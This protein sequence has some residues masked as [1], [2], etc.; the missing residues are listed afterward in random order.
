MTGSLPPVRDGVGDW[1]FNILKRIDREE[2]EIEKLYI[3]TSPSCAFHSFSEKAEYIPVEDYGV[4]SIL[5]VVR[6]LK[7]SKVDVLHLEYNCVGYGKRL[8]VNLLPFL[9]KIGL[10]E[11]G[12]I[13]T[14][15]EYDSYTW[16]GKTRMLPMIW[17]SEKIFFTDKINYHRIRKFK[18]NTSLET[19]YAPPNIAVHEGQTNED[20]ATGDEI[21]MGYWGFIRPN[22]GVELL[23][24]AFR[25]MTVQYKESNL[26]LLLMSELTDEDA[27]HRSIKRLI[28]RHGLGQKITVT[29][30]LSEDEV[31]THLAKLDFCVLPF[32]DGVSDRRGTFTTVMCIGIPVITT[33]TNHLFLPS[34][35]VDME[36]VILV[37]YT[38]E[39]ILSGMRKLIGDGGLLEKMRFKAKQWGRSRGWGY[40]LERISHSYR[41]LSKR[42]GKAVG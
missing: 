29:G 5:R 17:F 6:R 26:K 8:G 12:I 28:V 21:V 30:Y 27:Y 24:E 19:L 1:S 10:P 23:I 31:V 39:G 42:S 20:K 3:V 14:L 4:L 37:P 35:L 11:T 22:K 25:E 9:I 40:I 34:G 33:V 16:K 15:H 7:R 32:S 18:R 36:N 38:L 13:L 2:L 41:T